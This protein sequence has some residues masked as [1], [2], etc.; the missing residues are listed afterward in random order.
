MI[1]TVTISKEDYDMLIE[2]SNLLRALETCG[3][4]NWEGYEDALEI[5]EGE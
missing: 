4:D 1:E 5:L 3:V 2:A